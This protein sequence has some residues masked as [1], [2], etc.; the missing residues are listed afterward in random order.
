MAKFL[1]GK[2]G[3]GGL[4]AREGLKRIIGRTKEIT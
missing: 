2:R 1:V 4:R 3:K